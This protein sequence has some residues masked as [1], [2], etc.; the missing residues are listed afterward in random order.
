VDAAPAQ[1]FNAVYVGNL[2]DDTRG[3]QQR[4]RRNELAGELHPKQYGRT[5]KDL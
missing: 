4:S 2:V 5:R 1:V 3:K